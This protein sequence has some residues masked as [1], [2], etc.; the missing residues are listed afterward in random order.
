[1]IS[2]TLAAVAAAS[3]LLFLP[4]CRD[5]K[6]SAPEP[7]E[8]ETDTVHAPPAG[9]IF[10]SK[11]GGFSV[12]LPY[13]FGMPVREKGEV[14]GVVGGTGLTVYTSEAGEHAVML[15]YGNAPDGGSDPTA[16]LDSARDAAVR[17]VDATLVNDVTRD[18]GGYPGR[19][20]TLSVPAPGGK[21]LLGRIDFYLI[22]GRLYQ[23]CYLTPTHDDMASPDVAGFFGSFVLR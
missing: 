14:R 8:T 13:G 12:R 16:Q 9:P 15:A 6:E 19:S 23:L 10:E 4:C 21:T 11:E 7:I 22:N 20:V 1:M 17:S 18:H 2:R 3:L 5:G